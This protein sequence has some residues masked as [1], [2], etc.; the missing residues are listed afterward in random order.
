MFITDSYLLLPLDSQNT[1]LLLLRYYLICCIIS[2][3]KRG[4]FNGDRPVNITNL[5]FTL[6]VLIITSASYVNVTI[7]TSSLL[8]P[9]PYILICIDSIGGRY[10]SYTALFSPPL[11]LTRPATQYSL[12][13]S[14]PCIRIPTFLY[15]LIS[16]A[17]LSYKAETA[18]NNRTAIYALQTSLQT[19]VEGSRGSRGSLSSSALCASFFPLTLLHYRLINLGQA[20]TNK[21]YI[22]CLTFP[23]AALSLVDQISALL[24]G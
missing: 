6:P 16:K 15:C 14:R 4:C 7:S 12:L 5:L 18:L 23:L 1:L 21:N 22:I 11:I 3:V 19:T 13:S 2:L 9:K 20:K 24:K 8:R 17:A 10:S